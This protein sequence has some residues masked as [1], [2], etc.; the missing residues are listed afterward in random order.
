MMYYKYY[1]FWILFNGKDYL[2]HSVFIN[3]IIIIFNFII[4]IIILSLLGGARSVF[5]FQASQDFAL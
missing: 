1:K 2:G 4:I 3:L 5:F